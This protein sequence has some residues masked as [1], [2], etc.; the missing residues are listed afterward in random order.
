MEGKRLHKMANKSGA[1]IGLVVRSPCINGWNEAAATH[2]HTHPTYTHTTQ[3]E[4]ENRYCLMQVRA[5][6]LSSNL[7]ICKGASASKVFMPQKVAATISVCQSCQQRATRTVISSASDERRICRRLPLWVLATKASPK[8]QCQRHKPSQAP[9]CLRVCVYVCVHSSATAY[10]SEETEH[11]E[12]P[13]SPVKVS[14]STL[15]LWL[16]LCLSVFRFFL[17]PSLST[18]VCVCKELWRV[19]HRR[20]WHKCQVQLAYLTCYCYYRRVCV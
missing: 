9:L 4:R 19:L 20:L 6:C 7:A 3:R 15:S 11:W 12:S 16:S 13:L 2:T 8:E 14:E 1:I 10:A 18:F 5:I 17:S